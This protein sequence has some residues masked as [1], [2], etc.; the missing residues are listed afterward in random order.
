MISELDFKVFE[1]VQKHMFDLL[2]RSSFG[3]EHFFD[4]APKVLIRTI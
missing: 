2:R 3:A 1:G 4:Y